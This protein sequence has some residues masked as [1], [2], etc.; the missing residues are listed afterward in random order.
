MVVDLFVDTKLKFKHHLE[1]KTN[2]C[3][4]I[5]SSIKKMSLILPRKCLLTIYKGSVRPHL[6]YADITYHKTDNESFKKWLEKVQH[7]AALAITG[8]IRVTSRER[9]Y[10]ELDLDD[11]I[12]R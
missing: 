12:E 1:D 9:T 3:N 8:S 4:R 6:D 2:K 10:N 7:N 5:I 11:G